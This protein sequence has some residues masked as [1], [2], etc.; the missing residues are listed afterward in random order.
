MSVTR[1]ESMVEVGVLHVCGR[2]D[3]RGHDAED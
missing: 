2:G 1:Y 3:L